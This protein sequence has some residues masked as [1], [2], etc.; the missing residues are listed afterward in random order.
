MP[1][2]ERRPIVVHDVSSLTESNPQ[3]GSLLLPA[4]GCRETILFFAI[5]GICADIIAMKSYSW[6][7]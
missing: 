2:I 1:A 7:S 6:S 3:Q 4:G 5:F